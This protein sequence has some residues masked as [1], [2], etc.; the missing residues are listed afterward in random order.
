MTVSCTIEVSERRTGDEAETRIASASH[1]R[2][3]T[4]ED[5]SLERP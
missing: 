4:G 1:L 3:L 5:A 2:E